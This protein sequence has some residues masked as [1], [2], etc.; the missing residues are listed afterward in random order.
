[1]LVSYIIRNNINILN[2]LT[3]EQNNIV[4][5]EIENKYLHDLDYNRETLTGTILSGKVVKWRRSDKLGAGV[6]TFSYNN[7][8]ILRSRETRKYNYETNQILSEHPRIV[9][10]KLFFVPTKNYI[11]IPLKMIPSPRATYFWIIPGIWEK[12]SEREKKIHEFLFK[13]KTIDSARTSHLFWL[14]FTAYIIQ[15]L[16]VSWDLVKKNVLK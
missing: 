13:Y 15:F 2:I 10:Y 7:I 3:L 16:C 8:S 4:R 5:P 12:M 14:M 1:M 6:A 11:E 9:K